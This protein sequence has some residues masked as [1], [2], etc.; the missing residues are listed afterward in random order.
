MTLPEGVFD[1]LTAL[2]NLYLG[3]NAL[4]TLPEGVDGLT[5]LIELHLNDNAFTTLPAGVFD[6][7]TALESLHLNDNALTTLPEGVFDELTALRSLHLNDNAFTTLPAGIFDE[8]TAMIRLD[9]YGNAFT[10][11]PTG[12][13]DGLFALTTLDLKDNA[14]DPLPLTV[15]LEKVADGQFKAVSPTGAP[16]DMVLPL[17]VTNGSISGG[18]SSITISKSSSESGSLTVTRTSGTIADVTVN[19]GTLPGI[20]TSHQG[21]ALVKST[22]DLPLTVI[23]AVPNNDPVFTDGTSTTR[24][25]AENT[26]TNTNIGTAIAATDA[27]SGDTLTYTLSGTDAASFGIDSTTG[28]LE[29]KAALDYETKTSYSVTITVSDSNGGSDSITVT[30]NVTDVTEAIIDPPLSQRTQQVRAAIVAAVPGVNNANDVTL[31][32]LAAITSL[33]LYGVSQLKVGDFEGLSALTSI[34]FWSSDNVT[35]SEAVFSNL[36]ALASID[37]WSSDNVTITK[38][39]F[40][41]LPALASIDFWSVISLTISE[42]A[43]SNLPALA[44]IDFWESDDVLSSKDWTISE[45]AFSNLPVLARLGL[46]GGDLSTLSKGSFDGC[47]ALTELYLAD[48]NLRSLPSDIFKGLSALT[49]LWVSKNDLRSLPSDIFKGLSA[50]EVLTLS[51]NA[52]D[53]LPLTI[54]LQKVAEGQFK[55]VAPTG[56]P[57]DIVLPITVLHGSISGGAT[58]ITIPVGSVESS[59]LTVTR[60][61]GTTAAVTVDIGTL[62]SLPQNHLGYALQ[63]SADLPLEVI[64]DTNTAPVFTD[65]VSTTRTVA[66]NTAANTNIGTAIA[67]TDADTGDTLTYT[68]SGTDAASFSIVSTTGQLQTKAALDYETKTSY[69]VTITV[70][71]GNGGSDS[72]TVT[73]NVTDINENRAP[74]FADGASTTRTIAEN[75]AANT[76]IGTA[77]AATD[78]DTGDT[79][80][81]TLSGTDAASFSIV[82]TSGQ[83]Q[84]KAALDYET[85]TS[86]TVTAT[87]SDGNGGTDSIT[88]TINVTDVTEATIDPPLS[89]RTPQVR[90]AIVRAVPGVNSANDV[91]EAHLA[92]LRVLNL[93]DKSITSLKASDFDGMSGLTSLFLHSNQLTSLPAGVF[94]GLSALTQLDLDNNQFTTLSTDVFDELSALV[95]LGL[96][97]NQLTSLP[98]GVF[99]EPSTLTNLVLHN[100]QLTSLSAGV[101]DGLSSLTQLQLN[102]NQLTTLPTDVFD[103]LSAL[104][105]LYLQNNQLTS[106]SAGAFNGLTALKQLLL[107]NNQLTTLPSDVFDG[108]TAL[109][110][111][112]LN[113]N[114]LASLPSDIFDGLSALTQLYLDN[115]QLTTLASDIF[116]GVSGLTSLLLNN[117]Q[118]TS[119]PADVF[120][121]LSALRTL[122]LHNNQLSTVSAGVFEG[123]AVLNQ[124]L[125]QGNSVNPILLGVSLE[126]VAD[127]QFKAV[128]PAGATF[129]MVLPLTVTNGSIN[130]GATTVTISKGRV[131]S[132]TLTVTRTPGAAAAVTVNIGTLP[133]LP[134]HHA[135]YTFLKSAALP[136][137]VIS[138]IN[139]APVFTDGTSTTRTVAENTAAN[140]NIGTPIAATDADNDTLTYTLSGTDAASFSIVSTTGQ[141]QTNAAL[142]Y[143]TKAAYTVTVSVSDSNGGSES[144]T[145]TITV[146]DVNETP[147]NTAPVF[148]E[149]D[150]IT[151]T[152]AL[153]PK[154]NT[155][156]DYDVGNPLSATDPDGD[157][158]IFYSLSGTDAGLFNTYVFSKSV[159]GQKQSY[160]QLTTRGWSLHDANKSSF[161]VIVTASDR[162]GGSDSITLTINVTEGTQNTAPVFT[163]GTSTT[164]SIAEN[165]TANTNIGTAIAATDADNDTL[166]YTL[167]GT[168]AAS[169]GIDST[170]GQLETKAALDYETKTS[171]SVTITVSD[172]NGGSDSITVTINVTDVTE[173]TIDPPL[174]DRTPQ[175]RDAI[176]AA[177]P[178]VNS[179][180]NVTQAH[181]ATITSLNL[182][183]KGISELKAGDFD[184][185]S[186]LRE[187]ELAQNQLRT[188]PTEIFSGLSSLRTLYLNKNQLTLLPEKLFDGVTS[189]EHLHLNTNQLMRLPEKLFNGLVSLRQINLHTN[190][191]TNLPPKVF[192]G[193]PALLEISLRNNEL[194]D[195]PADVFSGLPLIHLYL[196]GNRLTDLPA[197]VFSGLSS[198][199]SLLLNNNQMSTLPT[200]VFRGLTASTRLWLHGNTVDPLPLIVS[201]EKGG[202]N[203]FKA[204]VTAGAPFRITLPISVANGSISSGATTVTI[205]QGSM[206]SGT[207]AV[208]RTPGTTGAVTVDIGILPGLPANHQGYKPTKSANLPRTIIDSPRNRGP[209][210]TEGA[211]TTRTVAENTATGIHIGLEVTATDA[212]NDTLTYSLG[213]TDAAAFGIDATTGQLK[214]KAALDYETKTSYSVTISVSDGNG[215]SNSIDVII[216]ITDANDAPLFSQGDNITIT[217]TLPPKGDT[218]GDYDVGNPLFATDADSDSVTYSLSG[219]DAN[220]FHTYKFSKTVNGQNQNHVQ[221]TT[222]GWSLHDANNSSFTVIVTASDRN[223]GS[224]SITVTINVTHT[225]ENRAPVFTDGTITTRTVAENTA[226]GQHIGTAVAATDADNDTLTYT[227]S[228]TDAASFGIDR[229]T[230]QLK[231]KAALDY[232]TK[233]TYT[234]IVTVSD[235]SLTDTI[236]VTIDI[237]DV[238][239][240]PTPTAICKVGDVLAPGESCTYPGTDTEFSVNN[241]G[242]GQFLFFTAANN[243][244]IKDTN[245]NGVSYT[246]VAK[247]LASGS[248]EIE[249]IA[250]DTNQQPDTPEQPGNTGGTPTPITSTIIAP[251]TEATLNGGIITLSIDN[252]T[253]EA[254][255]FR[256]KNAVSVTGIPG[257]MID[258]VDRV[259]DLVIAVEL[260][261]SG[262]IDTD[263]TLTF[264]V[265]AGAIADYTG[266]AFTAQTTIPAVTESVVPSTEAP[267]TE[268]TLDENIVT[269][270][271]SGRKFERSNFDIRGAVSVAGIT[272]VT[273]GSF[274]I[275][276]QSDT[277]VT[278]ELT[279]NGNLNADGTL[280]FTVGPD[281]IA[282][283]N[284]PTLTAQ[285][286]VSAST[287]V[288]VEPEPPIVTEK[289]IESDYDHIE[290]PWLWMIAPGG[291]IDIDNLSEASEGVITEAQIA[292]TGVNEGD[293]F[294]DLQWTSGRLLPTTV[295]G[296]F[297][298]SSDNV[299]NVVREIGLTDRDQLS[300]YSAYALINISSPHAQNDVLMGVGSDDSI[301]VWL[302][303]SVVYENDIE[304]RTKGIQNRFPVNLNA[305][306]NLLLIKVCNHGALISNNNW[307]MFFKLYLDARDYTVSLPTGGPGG[308]QPQTPQQPQQPGNTGGTPTLTASTASPLKEATLDESVVTL[309]L[310][311]AKYERSIFNIRGAVSVSGISGVTVR[312]F[313]IDR[314]SDTEVTVELT[315]NGNLNADGTLTFTVGA[316]AIA[317]YNGPAL[318]DQVSVSAGDAPAAAGGQDPDPA[319]TPQQPGNQDTPQQPGDTGGTPTLSVSTAVPLTE[320]TLHGGVVTLNLSSGIF[321]RSSFRIRNVVSVSGINGVTVDTFGVDRVSDTKITVELEYDGNMAANGTLT[322]SIGAGAIQDYNGVA[323]TA[324]L[325]IP[326]VT[327]SITASTAAPLTE[328]TLDESVVTL[329]LSGRK[330]ERWNSTI[331]GAVSVSGISGVTVRSFD[332]DRESDTEVTVEL[333][334]DGDMTANGTLTLTVGADAIAG[335]NGPALTDQVSVSAGDTPAAAGGQNPD[336]AQTPQQPGTPEQPQQPGNIGGTPTL[337]ASTTSA[338]TEATL[339]ESVV[340][341]TLSG[342]TYERSEWDIEDAVSV[343]GISGVTF[344][345]FFGL[346]R[347]NDTKVTIELAFSGNMTTNGT[348]TFTVDSGGIKDYNGAAL[349]AQIQVTAN[350]E[351][352][353]ASTTSPLKE[354]TLDGSVVTLTLSGAKYASSIWDIQD[355]VT[356]SGINGVTKPWNQPKRKS[357]TQITVKLEFDG[358][359]TTDGTLTFTVGADAIAGYNGPA[360]TA[361]VTVTADRENA[362]LANFPNPF[363]PETWIPYQLAKPT[364]VTITIYNI[365]GHAV[366]ALELGHQAAGIYQARSRAAYW[367]GR[368]AFGEP[369][370]SGVYFYRITAGDFTATRRMLIRK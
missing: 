89:D 232:E 277:E 176:V 327:E 22:T 79:L 360:L 316:G 361:Q 38:G 12:I 131:E 44:S 106:L 108:L 331:R 6:E 39:A 273:V 246:L 304:R 317:G 271:L 214:T 363:N 15:S 247:K 216:N 172:G 319:Q 16:F 321:E 94:D 165:T 264:T 235:G 284:G 161:T 335:Y 292:Q 227:L 46:W 118:L 31:A 28:Q 299:I 209:V 18:T 188:L 349:T 152:V 151:I 340:T 25:V 193:L 262:N 320:A 82:S 238:N 199:T 222:R 83:L 149:G 355:A 347:V 129:E 150:S 133:S 336:P 359:M 364:E 192:S 313:D 217:M 71:D 296:I 119:L 75:T 370:A 200:G 76:N 126:K 142:D 43:F 148:S 128:A 334:Y 62:P 267:L 30:I 177:V 159:N 3:G 234:V 307:G 182:R 211:N 288:P 315:F 367:D 85:K 11:L 329:T 185:L 308:Q 84:T 29:T 95:V 303:G 322:V 55:A 124:L 306:N 368:N 109:T 5:A 228:G 282:G 286:A 86:Y 257:V 64:S 301:K 63:K 225:V 132:G 138:E 98:I 353:A 66:E 87:V 113:I 352:V 156:G 42:G 255:V 354:A 154:G 92:A 162:N 19:I 53:P 4:T 356:V 51:G 244:N 110:E 314:E 145:V 279:F 332:I 231:T 270:T 74:V 140:T 226:S 116:D 181:L 337:T 1:E 276:R 278:V 344:D 365:N 146:T 309:T 312:S 14:V 212:D 59:A 96:S 173:A 343:S 330:F 280:T 70:S 243:L 33:D 60:T 50:L 21:Y 136:L 194:T 37:F 104:T 97:N 213:G 281:A 297:L 229:T 9:L 203:E 7:L 175:V 256:I 285:V 184:G 204:V 251:L 233:N 158:V 163:D 72:I 362:L 180:A 333:T 174:S 260:A 56:A 93:S 250:D 77:I 48:N 57:F 268:A 326:A 155:E 103:E 45:G 261:F 170:T 178:G 179:A 160:V 81:Y 114:E 272:G 105:D 338:L 351:S 125:L 369:V 134:Q 263:A 259:S 168:D 266:P 112:W 294:N 293:H 249:E 302:N 366:R 2:T 164:R 137:K 206:E 253:Y 90:N 166:T 141:L 187:I 258:S 167:S 67:A 101:F 17:T 325:S 69:S 248:W 357:D 275:D 254:S 135:G 298:C 283:Y 13:F 241:N 65:G 242:V 123:L 346:D 190:K 68:L 32:H 61:A 236:D 34:D 210:F 24:T 52:V 41:D 36:P 186:S 197:G 26:A 144:I 8:L 223:G 310:S 10:T 102:N 218:E 341:L 358:D 35:V 127:G 350:T 230:G 117:N 54:S 245:I 111:L 195:V 239:E 27:D 348:L 287:E 339:H 147:A 100:N 122:H 328:A 207:L 219:A 49:K 291:D 208:T 201:L 274:D 202:A 323:L 157:T 139:T 78:A 311:G 224:D 169:F 191:L 143:E 23:P 342:G 183:A 295:C 58:S 189:L 290:G 115:N 153:P 252:Q 196:D 73:I 20:P 305:G 47:S 289:P 120:D 324:Q 215:G 220:L 40:S 265:N 88:V 221:L 121:E 240:L 269:L 107:N 318:T 171:Y 198:L 345:G 91:T 99:D 80:T 205:P 130:G 237:T 300:Y